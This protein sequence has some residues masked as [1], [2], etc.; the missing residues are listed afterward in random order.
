MIIHPCILYNGS[1]A[2]GSVAG[3]LLK[4]SLA[5]FEGAE[6]FQRHGCLITGEVSIN[7]KQ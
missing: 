2:R 4:A 1:E 3:I 6:Y 7:I 5:V